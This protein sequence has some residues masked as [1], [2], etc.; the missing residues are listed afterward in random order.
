MKHP[1]LSLKADIPQFKERKRILV[2]FSGGETS[3]FMA[4]WIIENYSK[5]HEIRC[6]FANTGEEN[7]ET[8]VFADKCDKEFGLNLKWVEYKHR[9]FVLKN[10]NNASRNGEP[11][12]RLIQDFGIPTFGSPSCSRVL[13]ANTIA[14]YTNFTGWKR[15]TYFTAIGIRVDEID[16]MSSIAK[17][18]GLVYPLVK[19]EVTKPMVNTF[20]RD[21]PFRLNL[22]SYQGNCKTCWKKSFRTLAWIMKENPQHFNNFE[23][24]ENEYYDKAPL[25]SKREFLKRNIHMKFFNKGIG[26]EGIREIA[27][28]KELGEPINNAIEYV[29][30]QINGLDIDEGFGCNESCEIY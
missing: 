4:A 6:V 3:G 28:S 11:F 15:N 1:F 8:L 22:K 21:M 9:K 27:K 25:V 18:K 13:K 14:N 17:G 19:L 7:E 29:G 16:R 30:T 5:T 20:W 23:R 2:S 24:W 10:F 26:V 12:E